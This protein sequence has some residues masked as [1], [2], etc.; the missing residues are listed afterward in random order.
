MSDL[1]ARVS[2][3]HS[4]RPLRDSRAVIALYEDAATM[5]LSQRDAL[6]D[7]LEMMRI[8]RDE[9]ECRLE[10]ALTALAELARVR[11]AR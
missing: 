6:R 1:V 11:G 8:E 5:L 2:S 9:L 4:E 10:A 7:E 3:A